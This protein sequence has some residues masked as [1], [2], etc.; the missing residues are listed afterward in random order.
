MKNIKNIEKSWENIGISNDFLFGKVMQDPELCREM[1][2]RIFPDLE[3]DHI[4]YPEPQ[5]SINP[6]LDAKGIR[7]DIY[8]RG[9]DGAA[10]VVEMQMA[11]TSELPKRSRYYQSI[12]DLQLLDKGI[13]YKKL[14]PVYTIFICLCSTYTGRDAISILLS[15]HARKISRF[16]WT[17]GLPQFS[18]M[19]KAQW[20]IS[21]WN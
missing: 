11:D 15:T 18:S 5:K 21:A 16:L 7:L 20:M 1:L 13:H 4:E 9:S 17:T 2:Q 8:V 19:Q 6:D 10:Y 14:S 3:I 12:T